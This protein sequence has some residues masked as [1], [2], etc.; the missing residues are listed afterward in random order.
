MCGIL[1]TLPSTE[2]LFF[3]R[4]L[5]LLTHRGPDGFGIWYDEHITLGH[6]RLSI[7]DLSENGRQPM[8]YNNRWV[9]TFNGEIYNFIEIRDELKLKGYHFVSDT[10][11]EVVLASFQEWGVNCLQKFN[12]MWAMAI[13]D[14]EKK[15]LFLT[16]DR[17]GVKP[18]FYAFI[19]DK[20]IFASE[21]KAIFPFL[22]ERKLSP[23]FQWCLE[24]IYEYEHSPY[25]LIDGIQRFP[26]GHY[27]FVDMNA[28]RINLTSYWNTLDNYESVPEQYEKQ[29]DKFRELF[30]DACK[31]RMR[32]DVKIGTA[33]SGGLDSSS[34]VAAMSR[35][36]HHSERVSKDWQ[37]AFIAIFPNTDLD[38]SHYAKILTENLGIKAFFKE[39]DPEKGIADLENYLW[40]FEE[41]YL[42]SP[43]PMI[44]IYKTIKD[45]GITVSLD[46]HGADEL[47]AGYGN[48][49]FNIAKERPFDLRL[50]KEIIKTYKE[51]RNIQDDKELKYLI[52]GYEG[53][54][55]M[56]KHFIKEIVGLNTKENLS[57]KKMGLFNLYLYEIFHK[58]ILPTLLR[59]YD[60]YS[61][62]ASVEVRMPFMDYRLVAYCFSLPWQSKY[63]KGFTKA[64]L[65]D[66]MSPYMPP[67]ITW[68]KLKTGFGT[69]FTEWIRGPWKSFFL[70]TIH[71]SSFL[72]SS[73]IDSKT[74]KSK[75]ENLISTP[76]PTFI[77]G[78]EAWKAIMPY[79]WENAVLKRIK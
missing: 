53:R 69:P 48:A 58:T 38:E 45:N 51:I 10:D 2:P 42:T 5:N 31:I 19:E 70:D 74:V 57:K 60:R 21:M 79:F 11:T 29:V 50:S 32:A 55:N 62:A 7:L 63:R 20:F 76:T 41:L 14:K 61:M 13:W 4:A 59:N 9:I 56:I 67:E 47:L 26:A 15:T 54:K 52:D 28:K 34:I 43:I 23:R 3:E 12:G 35:I 72:N 68:R 75:I 17:F 49:L 25:C 64:I 27:G 24:H 16:R 18:L 44:E 6:R 71:S 8:E 46:G 1:G 78:Q 30:F 33:L 37:N 66:A 40:L 65:R 39:I 36:A 22:K 77:M 73:L